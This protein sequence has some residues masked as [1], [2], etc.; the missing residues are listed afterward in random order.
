MAMSNNCRNK[1][2]II[3]WNCQS[4]KNRLPQLEA[5]LF[6]DK[7]HIAA[8][9]ETWLEPDFNLRVSGYNVYR[10]DRCD[11]YGGVAILT[12]YSIRAQISHRQ[13]RNPGLEVLHLNIY[14]CESLNTVISSYCAPSVRTCQQ[15]WDDIF[16]MS[17]E[18]TLLLG[19]LN[20]HHR[21]WSY[22][23]DTRGQ[24]IFDSLLC[25][26]FTML[27][28]GAPTRIKLVNG[29]LKSS[30]PDVSLITTDIA[31]KYDWTV[32]S[33][34]LGSDHLVI[35]ISTNSVTRKKPD[36][37]RNFKMA[38]WLQFRLC[39]EEAFCNFNITENL[40]HSYDQFLDILNKA[41]ELHIPVIK[42]NQNPSNNFK[43]KTYWS[44]ALS[45]VVAERRLALV[46]FR[47]NPTPYNLSVLQSKIS[48]AQKDIRNAKRESWQKFCSSI[49]C[50]TSSSDMWR[51]MKWYKGY[52]Y[53]RNSYVNE[54]QAKQLLYSLT[55]DY[56][57]N[58]QPNFKS[59]NL[60]LEKY[61]SLHELEKNIKSSDTAPGCDGV[62]F[63][64]LKKL[65]LNAK[66]ILLNLFNLFLHNGFVPGQWRD[67]RI[68]PISKP[69]RNT[70]SLNSLR[71]ISLISC[72]CKTFHS[73]LNK[74]L[75]WYLERNNIFSECMVGFRKTR[76]CLDSLSSL[77]SKIQYGFA[78]N[79][80]TLSCFIDINNAY[81][82][83]D[84]HNLLINLDNLGVGSK[85]CNYLFNFL[86]ERSLQI[87]WDTFYL[88]RNTGFG[89]AQG[90]PL[91]PLLFNV[92]TFKICKQVY[93]NVT[94][95]QY[96]DDIV[97][98]VTS[99]NINDA[100]ADVQSMLDKTV[101]ILAGLGLEISPTKSK[102]CLF[103]KGR[104]YSRFPIE[105]NLNGINLPVVDCVKY[106]GLW[107]DCSLRWGKHLNEI[108]EKT[109]KFV[110]VFKVLSGSSWGVSQKHLR[111]LYISV[112]RSRLDYASFLY[113]NS[114]KK[115]L[116]K[117]DVIQNQC[118]RIIGGF[119][120][121]TPIHVM[122]CELSLPPLEIRRWFLAGKFWLKISSLETHAIPILEDL[123]KIYNRLNA[124]NNKT[125]L[126]VTIHG[127]L[128]GFPI[129]S[130]KQL[131][132]FSFDTWMADIDLSD[133][134]KTNID[135]I[136]KAK[137]TYNVSKL[138]EDTLKYMGQFS[139][140]YK[141]YTDGSKDGEQ[142]GSAF[143]DEQTQGFMKFRI[144][145]NISIMT[146]ELI[147][148]SEAL[149]YIESL[150]HDKYVVFTDSRSS[151]QHL[152]RCTSTF[153]GRPIAY[154]VIKSL[155]K[156]KSQNKEVIIQWIPSH[157]GIVGNDKADFLAK[158]AS[159]DGTDF[160][161]TPY[162]IDYI[163]VLKN[164][165]L[166]N[167][168]EYF[169]LRSREKGIWYRTIQPQ[170]SYTPW[171]DKCF[172]SREDLTILLRLRSGHMPLNKFGFIM[173]KLTSPLCSACNDDEEDTYHILMRCIR[174]QSQRSLI[175]TH[176]IDLSNPLAEK[177]ASII[178]MVKFALNERSRS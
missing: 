64:M 171:I 99:N 77:V 67:I 85:I 68:F 80:F 49:D 143:Y 88:Q 59:S 83:V 140:F 147:A 23:N 129:G 156:L 55:P 75:E 4:L 84:I 56:A 50:V 118:M 47:K 157:I 176:L 24:Q 31:I 32:A 124:R 173:K 45:K 78:K 1:I 33:E 158:E 107:M 92:A 135:F 40:Q 151:I 74:R 48:I 102:L 138:K 19:D 104:K 111:R 91:S 113:N 5:L 125:P 44:P 159:T 174:N 20:G 79:S 25:H 148:I 98:Y 115:Y 112:I 52:Y 71:P 108:V 6:Q 86:K 37:R 65:P 177:V 62:S 69:G 122:E 27:N 153:R 164:V 58:K 106:L 38:K 137:R 90:D 128:K 2:N 17:D 26:N 121:T 57:T 166:Q 134:L 61:I 39:L 141:I 12:H 142:I 18:K 150:D 178:H 110:N 41:A 168:K 139:E 73:I 53:N 72:L 175:G 30:S 42:I 136:S 155:L 131:K 46:Q 10:K 133:V 116:N 35:K 96:A 60:D 109:H 127:K 63:S 149:S 76:S 14:N 170:P 123:N 3:Q 172:L 43:P 120:R 114:T 103:S 82:N 132:M 126:L 89:L 13:I 146:V 130:C 7:I 117:L 93:N 22:K 34:N 87:K 154:T 152:A 160:Q 119:I 21:N 167:W 145:S 165:C 36:I 15:D 95:S 70:H 28:N 8:L 11:G 9:S 54:K 144:T 169:D 100:V 16:S 97:I 163:P 162:Y 101:T 81:N 105:I 161:T 94:V 51:K 66:V 29:V